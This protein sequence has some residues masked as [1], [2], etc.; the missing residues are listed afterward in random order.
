MTICL[1]FEADGKLLGDFSRARKLPPV[2]RHE[3]TSNLSSVTNSARVV[4][5]GD[6]ESMQLCDLRTWRVCSH[7]RR[8][9]FNHTTPFSTKSLKK[10]L[11]DFTGAIFVQCLVGFVEV[12]LRN[13]P[14]TGQFHVT[15]HV[16]IG[17]HP[18]LSVRPKHVP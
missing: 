17:D 8:N 4:R 15:E 11:C 18:S 16:Q 6:L 13:S 14:G 10:S 12:L 1:C 7:H 3:A 2:V 5:L 9:R